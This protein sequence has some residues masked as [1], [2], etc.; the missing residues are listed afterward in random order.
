MRPWVLLGCLLIAPIAGAQMPGFSNPD[1]PTDITMYIHLNGFQDAPINT[2]PPSDAYAFAGDLGLVQHSQGCQELGAT[3]FLAEPHHTSY[4]FSSPSLVQYD[5]DEAGK[6]K[7]HNE[8]GISYDLQLHDQPIEL[9]WYLETQVTT[10][11]APQGPFDPNGIP[12]LVPQVVM[13]ATL[14]EGD[15]ISVGAAA[16]NTGQRVAIGQTS[17]ADL[18]PLLDGHEH[19]TYMGQQQG[20]HLYEFRF[21][22]DIEK[23]TV[24]AAEGYNLRLDVFMDNPLC[25]TPE[26]DAYVMPDFVRTHTSPQYRPHY[27]WSVLNPL[28][29]ESLHPQPIGDDLV[30]HAHMNSVFG[31]YDVY[32]DS[33][34]AGGP[35]LL[36]FTG[37]SMPVQQELLAWGISFHHGAD[38]HTK[39]VAAAWGWPTVGEQARAGAYAVTLTIQNDQQNSEATAVATFQIGTDHRVGSVTGCDADGCKEDK[40]DDGTPVE[41]SPGMG[42]VALL[43]SVAAASRMVKRT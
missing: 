2:Q 31:N 10:G 37:P 35:P 30:V 19:V 41:Q 13:R 26:E 38:T 4:A 32:G 17:P 6:P 39:P 3:T 21:P 15:D 12:I 14:R 33:Y 23:A 42:L 22:L 40:R 36:A 34:D 9:V 8:R 16:Y 28:R 11:D 1:E 18:S 43:A 7:F 5:V 29:I 24:T 25:N 27:V 20:K